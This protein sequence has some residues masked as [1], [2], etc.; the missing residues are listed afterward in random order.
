MKK[1]LVIPAAVIAI[2]VLLMA[3]PIDAK[4]ILSCSKIQT[5][6]SIML[7]QKSQF[8]AYAEDE[9]LEGVCLEVVENRVKLYVL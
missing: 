9:L 1:T 7:G 4:T 8:D 5:R 2:A 6:Y 3:V